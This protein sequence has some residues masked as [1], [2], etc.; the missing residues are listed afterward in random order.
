[1]HFRKHGKQKKD[2]TIWQ[3]LKEYI[4]PATHISGC[5][6]VML[7]G[8]RPKQVKIDFLDIFYLYLYIVSNTPT[9]GDVWCVLWYWVISALGPPIYPIPL[10]CHIRERCLFATTMPTTNV[11]LQFGSWQIFQVSCT[12][13]MSTFDNGSMKQYACLTP[14][15]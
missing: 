15:S 12:F 14:Y 7:P 6:Q 2:P 13:T 8:C 10:H 3:L 5:A 11:S 9:L 1:M 4:C